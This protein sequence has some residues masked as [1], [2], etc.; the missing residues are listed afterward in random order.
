MQALVSLPGV[1][2]GAKDG[3][4]DAGL[5]VSNPG[6]DGWQVVVAVPPLFDECSAVRSD[7]ERSSVEK[8]GWDMSTRRF[9]AR[10]HSIH[11][12]LRTDLPRVQSI[13]TWIENRVL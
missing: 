4:D 9:K 7:G 12:G 1:F 5:V 6:D 10:L 8:D 11:I 3:V 2:D 13:S